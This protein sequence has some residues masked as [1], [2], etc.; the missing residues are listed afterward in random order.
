[1][2]QSTLSRMIKPGTFCLNNSSDID[3]KPVII[4]TLFFIYFI[5]LCFAI[6]MEDKRLGLNVRPWQRKT[7]SQECISI[8]GGFRIPKLKNNANNFVCASMKK[9]YSMHKITCCVIAR[10]VLF[11]ENNFKYEYKLPPI[12]RHWLTVSSLCY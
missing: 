8:Q 5:F 7:F 1:M 4:F 9:C 3:L 10:V 12:V 2:E 11:I 6:P